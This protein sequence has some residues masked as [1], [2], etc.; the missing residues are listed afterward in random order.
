M[1][2]FNSQTSMAQNQS[3]AVDYMNELT[4]SFK[5]VKEETWQYLK[6]ITRGKGA[7]KVE[8]KRQA[9]IAQLSTA[10]ADTKKM[11]DFKGDASLKTSIEKY[12]EISYI[13]L[14]E[15]FDKILDMEDISEQSYDAME[16]YLLAKEL[17][18]KK[19]DDAF[20]DVQASQKTFCDKND[21]TLLEG[22]QDKQTKK[23]IKAS[24]TLNYYNDLYLI[25]FKVYKQEAYVLD[26]LQRNDISSFT[27]NNQTLEKDA[28]AALEKL[29]AQ[30][31]YEGDKSLVL[32]AQEVT[33]FYMREAQ[34]DFKTISDFYT[35][36]DAFEKIQKNFEAKSKKDRTQADVDEI[37]KAGQEYNDAVA[38]F[39]KTNEVLNK[40]RNAFLNQWNSKVEAFM[41]KHAN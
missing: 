21:I 34:K 1:I 24:N 11:K 28:K 14:K 29:K 32:A 13:V 15:D 38:K 18:N 39:N 31:D 4:T 12:F 30:A 17:A 2:G 23:M 16:A 7:R 25:F 5:A 26:A 27:Q 9:L 37:N 6:A 19:L 8:S 20:S 40:E 22:E 41:D 3:S 10:K 33:T 35:K 36:K